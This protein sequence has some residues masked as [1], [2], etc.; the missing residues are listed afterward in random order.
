MS[1]PLS[2]NS[3]DAAL[4]ADEENGSR[5]FHQYLA[6]LFSW[7]PAIR[8]LLHILAIHPIE[9]LDFPFIPKVHSWR[10]IPIAYC[11]YVID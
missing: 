7:K 4:V 1:M 11:A 2:A 3:I 9:H 10:N 6:H 8:I 5:L